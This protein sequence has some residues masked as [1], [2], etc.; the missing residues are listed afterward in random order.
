MTPTITT[1]LKEITVANRA[2]AD[3]QC[4]TLEEFEGID[5][6]LILYDLIRLKTNLKKAYGAK[7]RYYLSESEADLITKLL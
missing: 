7:A 5:R 6:A 2:F 1:M 4:R 3:I